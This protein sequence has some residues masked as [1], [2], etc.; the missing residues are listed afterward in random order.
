[1][2]II[3]ATGF[4]DMARKVQGVIK[5]LPES[6][7]AARDEMGAD[8]VGK[9]R[10]AAAFAID[11]FT[12]RLRQDIRYIIKTDG[13]G[14]SVIMPREGVYVDRMRPHFV[15]MNA[16]KPTLL[17][18]G[19]QARSQKIRLAAASIATGHRKSMSLYV[20]PHPFI[21]RGVNLA[22]TRHEMILRKHLERAFV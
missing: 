17:A 18:W 16:D 4:E 13:T 21:A 12:G 7:T 10:Q 2:I 19:Q 9:L 15:S 3:Q 5:K 8:A 20:R 22:V 11:D 1:M 6:I 14:G